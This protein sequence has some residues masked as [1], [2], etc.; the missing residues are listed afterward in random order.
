M[1]SASRLP[2]AVVV[3]A[4]FLVSFNLSAL[5]VCVGEI[6][7]ALD[8][9][10][11]AVGAAIVAHSSLIAA[12]VFVGAKI[13][14]AFGSRTVFRA[15]IVLFGTA[16]IVAAVSPDPGTM[17]VAESMA[18]AAAAALLP[19]LVVLIGTH[20]RG[21]EQARAL[22]WLAASQAI[23]TAAALLVAGVVGA[24]LGWRYAFALLALVSAGVFAL[25]R[26]LRPVERVRR[27]GF[28][29][30]GL[31]L[32]GLAIALVLGGIGAIADWGLFA[33]K[34]AAPFAPLGVSPAPLLIGAGVVCGWA[35]VA[36][37]RRCYALR[38]AALVSV[39]MLDA[40]QERCALIALLIIVALG[41]AVRYLVP[42]YIE[43]VQGESS[44]DAARTIVP[45]SLAV[46]AA[47]ISVVTLYDYATPRAIARAAFVLVALGLAAL[48]TAVHND[49][50]ELAVIGALAAI[51]FAEG[52]L[53]SLLLNVL[54]AA[55]PGAKAAEVGS[56]RSTVG[57][58]G[59]ALGTAVAG[60][61]LI[62][63]LSASASREAAP[64]SALWAELG[65]QLDLDSVRFV[66][67]D[68]L[69]SLLQSTAVG[70]EHIEAALQFN[71]E[72]RLR[73]LK[74]SLLAL[75]AVAVLGA[76]PAGRLAHRRVVGGR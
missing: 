51:G 47:A 21:T 63:F 70:A 57:S 55:A 42:L 66:S 25:S 68:R 17:I 60:A 54:V 15:T 26:R 75:A 67:N 13:G 14:E 3:L 74:V 32:G 28:D 27:K 69:A 31:L 1:P 10:A 72:A 62:G 6:G 39:E 29:A 44:L 56:L 71:T 34:R 2:L 37:E 41:A 76:W 36:W 16:M 22:A 18:G 45:Y 19:T 58:L 50:S 49:W 20:Y 61:L 5:A 40:P 33:A 9:P 59:A 38:K 4:Q 53:L 35:F 11:S 30:V 23:A 24:W 65:A 64:D 52:I 8:A 48:G 12:L 73:A 43:V 7:E 46:F